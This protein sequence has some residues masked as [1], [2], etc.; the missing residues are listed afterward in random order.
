MEDPIRKKR[1]IIATS[2]HEKLVMKREEAKSLLGTTLFNRFEVLSIVGEGAMATV[3]KAKDLSTG[4]MVALKKL[5]SEDQADVKRFEQEVKLHTRLQHKNIVEAMEFLEAEDGK[6]FFVMEFLEGI[7]L[8]LYLKAEGRVVKEEDIARILIQICEALDHAHL[9]GVLHRDLKPGNIFLV[10]EEDKFHVKVLDFGIAKPIGEAVGLTQAGTAVGSPLY[11]SPEQCQGKPLDVRADVYALG[12][13][14]YE[15]ISGQLPYKGQ[16]MMT[17]M[18]AH[19]DPDKKPRFLK[20]LVPDLKKVDV[21]DSILRTAVETAPEKRFQKIKEFK[22]AIESWLKTVEQEKANASSV[23]YYAGADD[24]GEY[25]EYDSAGSGNNWNRIP[26]EESGRDDD[27]YED[28]YEEEELTD[29][30]REHRAR[31]EVYS[32]AD[33]KGR[34]KVSIRVDGE[35]EKPKSNSGIVIAI[36]LAMILLIFMAGLA[37][38]L[39]RG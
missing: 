36:V 15:V 38:M 33:Q 13:L 37:I 3:F 6:T 35:L 5:A 26:E 32:R 7:T 31:A 34:M 16:N 24:E 14:A 11:M 20:E 17:I 9:S 19:C 28:E 30:Q 25:D 4:R 1:E 23:T 10:D 2:S 8:E 39:L 18:A 27:E 12:I 22:K 21:L 29:V